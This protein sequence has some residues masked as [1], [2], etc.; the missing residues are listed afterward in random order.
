MNRKHPLP[1][2]PGYIEAEQQ[3]LGQMVYET[4]GDTLPDWAKVSV[5]RSI[6][7]DGDICAEVLIDGQTF[8]SIVTAPPEQTGPNT[9]SFVMSS[10]CK[11]A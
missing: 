1:L 4:F 5:L 8:G 2:P 11:W 6:D 3:V 9:T 10:C 7:R